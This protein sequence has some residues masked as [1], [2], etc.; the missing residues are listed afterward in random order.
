MWCPPLG[1]CLTEIR[2]PLESGRKTGC[3]S[4]PCERRDAR[5]RRE[6]ASAGP[7]PAQVTDLRLLPPEPGAADSR[8][9]ERFAERPVFWPFLTIEFSRGISL[10]AD[11]AKSG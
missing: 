8:G 6:T 7:I 9:V 5:D 3:G 11:L 2:W 10:S 1:Q 4:E